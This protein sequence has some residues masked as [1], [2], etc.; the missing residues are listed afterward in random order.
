MRFIKP[1]LIASIALPTL[2]GQVTNV[3][4]ASTT[5]L[6]DLWTDESKS[7]SSNP[8]DTYYLYRKPIKGAFFKNMY[9]GY[10]FYYPYAWNLDAHQIPNYA[11]LY[12]YNFRID[13]TV[14]NTAQIYSTNAAYI[15][16]TT[17]DIKKYI[18]KDSSWSKSNGKFRL[19]EYSRPVVKGISDDMNKYAYLFVEKGK[20]VYT[21]QLKTSDKHYAQKRKD[22]LYIASTFQATTPKKFDLKKTTK[23]SNPDISYSYQGNSLRI[24]KNSFMMGLYTSNSRDVDLLSSKL[25][26]DIG[27][28]FFYKPID[29]NFDSYTKELLNKKR[30]PVVTFLLEQGNGVKNPQ[31]TRDTISGKYD[32]NIQNWAQEIKKLNGPVFIRFGNEMN[33]SWAQWSHQNNYNDPDLYKL[34]YRHF[35]DIFRKNNTKN[36]YF[37]WNPNISSSPN[38]EWNH[39]TMY[40]PGDKYVDWIGLTAYN[41]G[42]GTFSRFLYF[43]S[44][45]ENL[46]YDYSRAF[47]SKPMLI[48]EFGSVETGGSKAKFVSEFFAKIPTKYT[49]IKIALWFSAKHDNYNFSVGTSQSS[50]DAF[51]KNMKNTNVIK[52]LK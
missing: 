21:F 14:Q 20:F 47:S 41:F 24:P 9:S 44:L 18:T 16:K 8:S 33:G 1:I 35:V 12:H 3:Q 22:L 50:L 38:Y 37:V 34:A 29:S 26:S 15:S 48:G 43:D 49:N 10:T 7:K 13:I 5:P 27:S 46:Y 11:R 40:Y 2:F 52:G 51:T 25:K 39:A 23:L 6:L 36:A 42:N 28:Q 30:L 4:A 19:V 32:A 17:A 45:Y 31:I